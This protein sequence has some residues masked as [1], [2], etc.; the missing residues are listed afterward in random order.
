[1]F[2]NFANVADFLTV[3][4]SEAH[5]MDEWPYGNKVCLNQP[6]TIEERLEIANRFVKDTGYKVPLVV[7]SIDNIFESK[8]ASWPERY[9]V[10]K[11][12]KMDLVACPGETSGFD[13]RLLQRHLQQ[14]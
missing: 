13:L 8:F 3:Y 14:L 7:D 9:Y 12:G 2:Q 1:L 5:T 6:K 4:I 10:I 11:D